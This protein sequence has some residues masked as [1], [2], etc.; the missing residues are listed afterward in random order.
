[1]P[2][3]LSLSPHH[4]LPATLVEL[5]DAATTAPEKR[6]G[7]PA[8]TIAPY[9]SG[10]FLT[11]PEHGSSLEA[12]PIDLARLL[13]TAQAR[14][15][16]MIRLDAEADID[17]ALPAY[18]GAWEPQPLDDGWVILVPRDLAVTVKDLLDPDDPRAAGALFELAEAIA[19][20][21]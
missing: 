15:V 6:V 4:L 3:C 9:P 16:V 19:W 12:L 14:G 17:D 10:V 5:A 11:V 13:S 20:Q 7:W 1:M 8:M 2:A 21:A 18:R